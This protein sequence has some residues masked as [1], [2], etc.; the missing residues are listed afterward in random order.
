MI[1]KFAISYNTPLYGTDPDRLVAFAQHAERCGF[2][3][4]YLPDH[5]ALHPGAKVGPIELDPTLAFVDPLDTLSFVA[6]STSSLLLGTGVL[7]LPYRHPVVLAKRLATIDQLSRGRMRLLTVGLGALPGEAEALGVDYRSRGRRADEAI[8]VLR[9]LWSGGADGTEFHGEFFDFTGLC[10]YPKPYGTTELPVH[11]G[12]SSLAAARR[13][14]RHGDGWF[15]GGMLAP[16]ERARQWELVRDT[17][18]E[19]GRDPAAL[20]Y[21]RW[22]SIDMPTE[23]AEGLASQGV[24]RIVVGASASEPARQF[25]EMSKL[26]ERFG[27]AVRPGRA[28]E[29]PGHA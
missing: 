20:E 11:I 25:D 5:I 10:S 7:L 6:A 14:G 1:V 26:A 27:L 12:G 18:I 16:L 21:T 8:Q 24:T 15:P 2:E 4:L 9:A 29:E 22:G 19:A 23:R 28:G 13:A 17:A 3:G